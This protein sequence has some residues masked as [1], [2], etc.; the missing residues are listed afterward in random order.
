MLGEQETQ[1]CVWGKEGEVFK[2]PKDYVLVEEDLIYVLKSSEG[3]VNILGRQN[4]GSI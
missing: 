1:V 3:M 2:Y 4:L